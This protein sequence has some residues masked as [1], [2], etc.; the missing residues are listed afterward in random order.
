LLHLSRDRGVTIEHIV[1]TVGVA[2]NTIN[3]VRRAEIHQPSPELLERIAR[4]FGTDPVTGELDD[5]EMTRVYGVL[6]AAYGYADPIGQQTES[7]I[8]LGLYH[9]H[10][11]LARARALIGLIEAG[12]DLPLPEIRAAAADVKARAERLRADPAGLAEGSA[13]P[14]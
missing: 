3:A 13:T 6:N 10:K 14:S 7:L 12:G 1:R 8:E 11:S 4:A 9:Q 5:I 2:R